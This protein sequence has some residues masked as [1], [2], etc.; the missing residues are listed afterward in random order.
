MC[1]WYWVFPHPKTRN[2][3]HTPTVL[4]QSLQPMKCLSMG[5]G[6]LPPL[7]S[8]TLSQETPRLLI[9]TFPAEAVEG[10]K[11]E[12]VIREAILSA[13][14]KSIRVDGDGRGERLCFA[15]L[16]IEP[17]PSAG[18]FQCIDVSQVM[19][20]IPAAHDNEGVAVLR[21]HHALCGCWKRRPYRG[22]NLNIQN[23]CTKLIKSIPCVQS[24]VLMLKRS[25]LVE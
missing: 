2:Y 1:F 6:T 17:S 25:V 13:L 14:W 15:E 12:L 8:L 19:C 21:H 9:I 5:P 22:R 11:Q 20:S 18:H 16:H 10:R 3:Y 24:C 4:T 7:T 23:T